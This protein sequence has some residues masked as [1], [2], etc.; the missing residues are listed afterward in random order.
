MTPENYNSAWW[1]LRERYQGVRPASARGEEFFDPGAKY[2]IPA[3]TPYTR[4]FLSAVLQFQFHRALTQTAGCT[5]PLHR[6][7]IYGNAEAGKRLRTALEM[8]ASAVGGHARSADR[9]A[10]DGRQR[11]GRLLRP[12]QGVAGRA[13]QGQ[14]VGW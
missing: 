2:H 12:A 5:T 8:G 6:C 4:Y 14:R 7:S 10:R 9:P 3:N 13:E 1:D 11:H